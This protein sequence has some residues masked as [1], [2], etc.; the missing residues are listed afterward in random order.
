VKRHFD[1]LKSTTGQAIVGASVQVNIAGTGTKASLFSD[2][3]GTISLGN[4]VTT[5][6]DG[7]YA[8]YAAN[9]RYD[10]V[11]SANGFTGETLFDVVQLFDS[12]DAIPVSVKPFGAKGD[13]VTDDTAA[14]NAAIAFAA[15]LGGGRVFF[16]RGTYLLSNSNPGDSSWDNFVALWIKSNN[17]HLEGEG[18][19]AT[20]LKLKNAANCHVV[21]FGQ[22][23]NATVTVSNC[24][25][26]NLSI[27]GNKANQ[28]VPDQNN[29]HWNGVDVSSGCS[30]VRIQNLNVSNTAYYGI[31]MQRDAISDSLIENVVIDGP[32]A[33]GIDWKND[34]GTGTGNVVRNVS[35]SNY[36]ALPDLSF[37]QCGVDLRSGIYAENIVIKDM[38][39]AANLAGVRTLGDNDGTSTTIPPQ[40]TVI[41]NVNVTGKGS[42]NVGSIGVAIFTRNTLVEGGRVTGCETGSVISRIDSKLAKLTLD[43]N[44]VGVSLRQDTTIASSGS[45]S[46]IEG[47]TVR[48]NTGAGIEYQSPVAEVNVIGC[49][50]RSN[51]IGHDIQS[52]ASFVRI[53]GGS[54]V[55]NTTQVNDAGTSTFI[56]YVSGYRTKNVVAGSAAIDSTGVKTVTLNHSLPFTPSIQDVVLSLNKGSAV[57]DWAYGYLEVTGTTSSQITA[58]LKVT[59]ASATGGATVTV[60]ANIDAKSRQ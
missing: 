22:R 52:G 20:T 37:P 4:P 34:S 8:F 12:A 53:V 30:K 14:I 11:L 41:K 44:G 59:T 56:R 51:G 48:S 50:V 54:C 38:N 16:P 3:A 5:N 29:N 35:V 57:T 28:T 45:T 33:D 13:G 1:E 58:D 7:E 19:G 42:S 25:I 43:T 49:D 18:W 23:A 21:K 32:G 26:S 27:D 31:G 17:I 15:L 10:I 24:S 9:G 60:V 55:S 6:S 36:G 2:A 40:P 46:E 39:G 47:C